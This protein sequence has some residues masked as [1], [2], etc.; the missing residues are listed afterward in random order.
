MTKLKALIFDCDGVIA[1]TEGEGHRISFNRVFAE[2]GLGVEWDIAKYGEMLKIAGGK[3]RMRPVVYAPEFTKDVGDKDAYIAKLHKRKTDLYMEMIEAGQLPARPGVA[4]LMREARAK[5]LKLAIASTSNE[6]GVRLIAQLQ[7][8]DD[9]YSSIDPILAGDCVKKKKPAPD[10]YLLAAEKLGLSPDECL[11][12]EDTENGVRAAR[13]AGMKV[14]VTRSEYSKG[15][16]FPE[17]M[18]VVDELGE[19]AEAGVTIERLI[20]L[21]EGGRM[22]DLSQFVLPH[23]LKSSIY[24]MEL[25]E[26]SRDH[27]DYARMCLNENPLPP[28]QKVLD[29]L[30]EGGKLGHRYPDTWVHLRQRIGGMFGLQPENVFLGNGSSETIDSMMRAFLAPGDE[31]LLPSPTFS[32][33]NVR[34]SVV[35]AKVV[36]VK[37]VGDNQEYSLDNYLKA[38]TPKTKLIVVVTPN[39]PTCAFFKHEDF[40]RLL[41]LGIPTCID[42]AYL[43]FHPD[44]PSE[45]SLVK[46]YPNAFVSHTVSKAYGL[47][48]LRF[49]YLLGTPEMV[50]LFE[51]LSLPWNLSHPTLYAIAAA[52]E[53]TETLQ[54]NIDYMNTWMGRYEEV[55]RGLGLRPLK[56]AGNYMLVDASVS[57]KTT[58]EIYQAG[59]KA[60]VILKTAGPL[61]GK[62]GWFRLTPGTPEDNEKA[63]AFFKSYFG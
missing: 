30:V 11:V 54:R 48:G 55:L 21:F 20:Q 53:D 32:L 9:V 41:E 61:N 10:I 47:A 14:L 17:A 22:F 50:Q 44:V 31:V 7:L 33:F 46:E 59:L 12:V 25:N 26:I 49:G 42:E 13:A 45:A 29:A 36:G 38:V 34:A 18:L 62:D 56:H 52:L 28:S 39:N 23:I 2:E 58:N 15:E 37:F 19:S 16:H 40:K 3:E 1:E 51:R 27:P 6:R 35:G 8:G 5:G 63:F 24:G 60:G 4:R 43:E 57:G